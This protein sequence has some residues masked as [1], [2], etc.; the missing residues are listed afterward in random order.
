MH[1]IDD[2]STANLSSRSSNSSGAD[3]AGRDDDWQEMANSL[4]IVEEDL[5]ELYVAA[6]EE[7]MFDSAELETVHTLID[8]AQVTLDPRS[9]MAKAVLRDMKQLQESILVHP[10]S[11]IFVRQVRKLLVLIIWS[12]TMQTQY[13]HSLVVL[14]LNL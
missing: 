9:P 10:D 13:T 11:A 12:L 7:S 2:E 14:Y 4:E 3:P 6:L 8:K 5:C 1:H